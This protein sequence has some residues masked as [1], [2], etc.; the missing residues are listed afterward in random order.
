MIL[1]FCFGNN[2]VIITVRIVVKRGKGSQQVAVYVDRWKVGCATIDKAVNIRLPRVVH[3]LPKE[4]SAMRS[5]HKALMEVATCIGHPI[6]HDANTA[7][8]GAHIT[9]PKGVTG[10]DDDE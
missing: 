4:P 2:V 6:G 9:V 3:S 1:A 5:S 10:P 7:E 8:G